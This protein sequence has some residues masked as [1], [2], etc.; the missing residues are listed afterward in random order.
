METPEMI[1][2]QAFDNLSKAM[3]GFKRAVKLY[4]ERND[5]VRADHENSVNTTAAVKLL[6]AAYDEVSAIREN[7]L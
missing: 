7:D 6:A 4:D 3:E 1:M 2:K 5:P